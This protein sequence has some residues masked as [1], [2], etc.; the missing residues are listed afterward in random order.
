MIIS[1]SVFLPTTELLYLTSVLIQRVTWVCCYHASSFKCFNCIVTYFVCVCAP[2][3]LPARMHRWKQPEDNFGSQSSPF[4]HV[5]PGNRT[6]GMRHGSKGGH[7]FSVQLR[8]ALNSQPSCPCLLSAE[9]TGAAVSD[10]P[11]NLI[12][13]F[14]G[15]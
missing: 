3:P 11:E 9:I 10:I 5:G 4:Y 13:H 2:T 7:E 12:Q 8:W 15:E 14:W 1:G 6:Q